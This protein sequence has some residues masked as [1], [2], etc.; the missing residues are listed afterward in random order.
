MGTTTGGHERQLAARINAV[1]AEL[2]GAVAQWLTGK[3]GAKAQATAL[4]RDL[5]VLEE[6]LQAA[7]TRAS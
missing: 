3:P 7:R 6:R 4:R 5:L 1:R 2:D